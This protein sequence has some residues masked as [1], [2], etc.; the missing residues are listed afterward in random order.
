MEKHYLDVS[1][2]NEVT[3][4]TNFMGKYQLQLNHSTKYTVQKVY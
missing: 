2:A 3:Y 4:F 1:V